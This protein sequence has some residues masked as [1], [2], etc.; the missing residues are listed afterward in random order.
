MLTLAVGPLCSLFLR[1]DPNNHHHSNLKGNFMLF[2]LYKK[3]A[4]P[5][6]KKSNLEN[7]TSAFDNAQCVTSSLA[8]ERHPAKLRLL[9]GRSNTHAQQGTLFNWRSFKSISNPRGIE[10]SARQGRPAR[11]VAG[12][13][14]S[15]AL[16][17]DSA[18]I[19]S[20]G[21]SGSTGEGARADRAARRRRAGEAMWCR[22]VR[23]LAT[24][25][26]STRVEARALKI[27]FLVPSPQKR[28]LIVPRP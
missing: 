24:T 27:C 2:L 25:P 6:K 10:S 5:P 1:C 28:T 23:P 13:A 19:P 21:E 8:R 9:E 20:A 12:W 3:N 26:S 16:R 11:F 17:C 4:S 14:T 7:S 22:G 15:G 18:V